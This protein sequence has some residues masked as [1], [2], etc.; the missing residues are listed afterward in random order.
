MGDRLTV[1]AHHTWDLSQQRL[2]FLP[3]HGET[4]QDVFL[5][6]IAVEIFIV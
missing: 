6:S 1:L 2:A 5:I 4:V 3:T